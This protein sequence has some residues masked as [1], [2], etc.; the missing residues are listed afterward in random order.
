MFACGFG[1]VLSMR[2]RFSSSRDRVFAMDIHPLQGA[3]DRLDR[4][5]EHI[6]QFEVE[7]KAFG[8]AYH[9][10]LVIEP[11]REPPPDFIARE[12]ATVGP[13]TLSAILL[14]EIVYNLRAAMDYLVF[15][16]AWKD[17]GVIQNGTQFPICDSKKNFDGIAPK[18]L[19]GLNAAHFAAIEGLQPYRGCHWAAVLRDISNPDKHRRLVR[20]SYAFRIHITS[21]GNAAFKGMNAPA[22]RSKHRAIRP[23]GEEVDVHLTTEAPIMISARM[24]GGNPKFVPVVM[25]IEQI[26][27]GVR[28]TLRDFEPEF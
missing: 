19:V 6:A 18:S 9:N 11:N 22:F 21:W 17:A 24:P 23:S 7:Q 26:K 8:E 10:N 13:S 15:E 12:T 16:L 28:N 3:F 4:A 25:L 2:L 27:T 5:E 20:G 1:R 14:G